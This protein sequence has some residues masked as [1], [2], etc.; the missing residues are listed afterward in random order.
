MGKVI[1]GSYA[2]GM[3]PTN[4][5]Y[6]HREGSADTVAVDPGD[7][8]D[9]IFRALS[10]QKLTVRAI[11]L[12][13]AHFDHIWG[14]KELRERTGAPVYCPEAEKH[15]C[16][17]PEDNLSAGYGRPCT[18]EPDHWLQDSETVESAG[19]RLQ[20]LATPGHT[21]GSCCYYI[22]DSAAGGGHILL[23]GDTLFQYSV[24]RTDMATGSMSALVRSLQEKLAPLPDD[25]AVYPGH[26][27]PTVLGQEKKFNEYFGIL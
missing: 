18:V 2:V 11:L 13:H 6:L 5:Y 15:L 27:E 22:D 21:E 20:M 3:L 9:Q 17:D 26:G 25:T 16:S 1:V 7:H 12:T 10:E 14:L 8:G 19:I 24:G 23:S 4:F